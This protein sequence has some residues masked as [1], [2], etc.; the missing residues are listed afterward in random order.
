MADEN[1]CLRT[2]K[3]GI[4]PRHEANTSRY[5]QEVLLQCLGWPMEQIHPQ[6]GR[7]GFIDYKLVFPHSSACL[8]VEV[9]K[10]GAS[11]KD[12]Q[13]HKYLV[14]RGPSTEDLRVGVLTNL[15][16]WRVYVAGS[17]VRT[18]AGVPMVRVKDIV[19]QRRSDIAVLDDLIGY[20]HNGRFK[21]V[22]AALG[23]SPAVLRHLMGNDPQLLK[24]VRKRL[25]E[26]ED[27]RIPQYEPLKDMIQAIINGQVI[28]RGKFSRSKLLSA[29]HSRL[30]AHVANKRLVT[31]FGTRN[32][33]G[34]VRAAINALLAEHA[35]LSA[36]QRAVA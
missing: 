28:Q 2:I 10:F 19:T 4:D 30:V 27:A 13:I 35:Q 15:K 29:L 5:V 36:S 20:R 7:R 17:R 3:Q 25:N 26:K 11:L 18:V 33:R 21:N 16:E 32:R 8:H 24:A 9:K 22:R 23:E 14:R 31:L 12:A 6:A 1:W 34:K